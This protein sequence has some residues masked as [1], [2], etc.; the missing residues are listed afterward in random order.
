MNAPTS[1]LSFSL[2][3]YIGIIAILIVLAM[4][5]LDGTVVNVALP[6]LAGEFH[7]SDSYAVW[8]VTIY[9]LVITML[10]LPLSSLAD[11][12]SYRRNFLI[13]VI[14]FT[15][16]SL[17]C[18]LSQNFPMIL[19]ARLIQGVGAAF[20]MGVT[21]ALIRLIYP[22]DRLGRGLA[23]NAM[24][25]AIATAAG[26]TLA[27]A[28][29]SA[30]NW[31]WL[32]LIN[33]PFG[34]LAYI[35]GAK[36]L[37]QNPPKDHKVK[38]DWLSGIA[39]VVV[40]G[41]IFY[42]L[43]SFA[44]KGNLA[45]SVCLVA[46]ALVVGYLYLRHLRG[47]EDPMLPVDLLHNRLYALSIL[48]S[49]CSFIAQTLAMVAIPFLFLNGFGFSELTTGLLMTPWPIATMIASPVAARWIER[50]N[51]GVTAAVGMLIY[52]I[53]V[54]GLILI[55]EGRGVAEWDIAWRMAVCG[56]GFGIFQTPNNVVMIEATPLKRSGAAGGMQ[57][58]TRLVGQ[59]L[60]AT[61]VTLVFAF[62]SVPSDAGTLADGAPGVR[63]CL[64]IAI[65]FALTAGIFSVSRARSVPARLRT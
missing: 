8:I 64:Y 53:G 58:T 25:I 2:H 42:S 22:A 35:F 14:V 1:R 46:V 51:A 36:Y 4:T 12:H 43:G 49:N 62:S 54:T 48:T 44:L 47:H 21:V 23:I 19:G 38:F 20:I 10:L 18:A 33:L 50:H 61:I 5:V 55:P 40:F 34:I 31:H 7:V 39:N 13:G 45:F 27:G 52:A 41:L 59:T 63:I 17:F 26:P 37:P 57:S 16:G 9:Q 65:A 60:G 24:V 11:I 28:I 32:F 6:V 56:L 29:L 3:K 15:L 30:S